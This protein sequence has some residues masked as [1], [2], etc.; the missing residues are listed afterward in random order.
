MQDLYCFLSYYFTEAAAIF[1][2]FMS[3]TEGQVIWLD[4]VQCHGNETR[5]IDC[6]ANPLEMHNCRHFED[7]GVRCQGGM[8]TTCTAVY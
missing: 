1:S 8:I 5:L 3:G 4:D 6:P 2:G 7:A